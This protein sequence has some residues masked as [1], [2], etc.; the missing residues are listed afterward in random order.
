MPGIFTTV[1][2]P[3]AGSAEVQLWE[4]GQQVS[5]E[6][7]GSSFPLSVELPLQEGLHAER[8][9]SSSAEP[10]IPVS[11]RRSAQ[12]GNRKR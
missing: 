7:L 12:R 10:V 6:A 8:S 2:F 1:L 5:P 9:A 3:H 4:P 11:G